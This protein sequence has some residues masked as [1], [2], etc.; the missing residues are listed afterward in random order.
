MT[1]EPIGF[2]VT[3]RHR[4]PRGR[5]SASLPEAPL[6]PHGRDTFSGCF[7][8]T[9]SSSRPSS[10][11]E[12]LSAQQEP[13]SGRLFLAL[14]VASPQPDTGRPRGKGQPLCPQARLP[15]GG[16]AEA[17][18]GFFPGLSGCPPSPSAGRFPCRSRGRPVLTP[19][20]ALRSPERQIGRSAPR[21][22]H[23]DACYIR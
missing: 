5:L 7:L 4:A 11:S 9:A 16:Q 15:L 2:S 13:R 18:R 8:S 3:C 12:V 6:P 17:G 14:R 23:R 20:P 10:F 1:S 22:G 21:G 19:P